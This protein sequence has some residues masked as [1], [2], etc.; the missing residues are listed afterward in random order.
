[1]ER[2]VNLQSGYEYFFQIWDG[3]FQFFNSAPK[4]AE[5]YGGN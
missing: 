2:K 4:L 5:K 1:M 3:I